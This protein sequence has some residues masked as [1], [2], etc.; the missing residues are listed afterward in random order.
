MN[1]HLWAEATAGVPLYSFTMLER[2]SAYSD[3]E[4]LNPIE[5]WQKLC[6]R[7]S[8][9]RLAGK[10]LRRQGSAGAPG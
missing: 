5:K 1:R 6:E 3:E 2:G 8:A 4:V 9:T 10:Q 7:C